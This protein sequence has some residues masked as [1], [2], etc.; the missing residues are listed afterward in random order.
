MIKITAIGFDELKEWLTTIQRGFKGKATEAFAEYLV[1]DYT[2]GL[3]KYPAYRYVN[4]A[5]GF[6]EAGGGVYG[7]GWHSDK[8]RKYVMAMIREGKINPGFVHRTGAL[9]EGWEYKVSGSGRYTIKNEVP[10]AGYIMGDTSQTRMHNL[11]GWKK[12]KDV[13]TANW[14]GAKRYAEAQIRKW[15]K[16]IRRR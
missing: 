13:I 11:I 3:K 1:G 4:R 16:E 6:P 5:A 10:Y 14:H 8:Q 2:H 12:V 7:A 9:Q 15:I